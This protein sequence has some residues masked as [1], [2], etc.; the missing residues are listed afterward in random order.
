M[1]PRR[2]ADGPWSPSSTVVLCVCDKGASVL[3]DPGLLLLGIELF[4]AI[5]SPRRRCGDRD[6]YGSSNPAKVSKALS[7]RNDHFTTS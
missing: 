4:N 6:I 3:G 7:E 2:P 1:Q 5:D